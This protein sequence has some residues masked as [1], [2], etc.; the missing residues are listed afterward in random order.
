MAE[1]FD[2]IEKF[3]DIAYAHN[4]KNKLIIE[5][6]CGL[7]IPVLSYLCAYPKEADQKIKTAFTMVAPIDGKKCSLLA[8]MIE[9]SP[10]FLLKLN[11]LMGELTGG[12]LHGEVIRSGMDIPIR[13]FFSKTFFGRFASGWKN[14]SFADI[15]KSEDL[16]PFQRK[17]LAGAYWI[18]PENCTNFPMPVEQVKLSSGLFMEGIGEDG[19]IPFEYKGK[20]LSLKSIA[21]NTSIQL[22][23][24]YGA[25]DHLVP[26]ETGKVMEKILKDR[27]RHVVH[28]QAGHISYILSPELWEKSHKKAFQ[29][30]IID[31]ILELY[32][33]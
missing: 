26:D 33:K 1:V 9:E 15:R 17:D 12:Y 11:F 29:P 13:G 2:T 18:S 19:V 20:K 8:R 25:K 5:G 31:L 24:F 23:G 3:T 14:K 6:Y 21:E 16:S 27:Y 7:G 28:P 22:A 32:E 10:A 4:Q 30:N